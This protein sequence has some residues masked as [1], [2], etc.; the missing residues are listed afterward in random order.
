VSEVQASG[1]AADNH[2]RSAAWEYHQ[3][4]NHSPESVRAD[5]HRLDWANQPRPY[6]LYAGLPRLP[7]PVDPPPS[8]MPALV[9]I[10]GPAGDRSAPAPDLETL[11]SLLHYS[12]GIIRRLRFPGGVMDFRAAACT[13]ALYHIELYIV[14]RDLPGLDAGVYQFGAHDNALYRLRSGD[15]RAELEQAA[16]A[17][18][19]VARA[20]VVIVCT[21]T[22]WR[23][24]WK[25]QARAYRHAF[26]DS[27]TILANL[28][29]LA[30][31]HNLQA[32]I[33]TGFVDNAVS[34][35]LDLDAEREAALALIPIGRDA[36]PVEDVPEVPARLGL[37]TVPPSRAEVD[38]AAIRRIH[39]ASSLSSER[40][41]VAWRESQAEFGLPPP[42]RAVSQLRPLPPSALPAAPIEDVIRRRGSA[43]RFAPRAIGIDALSSMLEAA[44]AAIPADVL[45]SSGAPMSEL[46]LIVRAVEGLES[47]AY[48]Y[49][50]RQKALELLRAGD[51]TRQAEHL[52][53]GQ[54]LGAQAAV[55]VYFLADLEVI[56]S[57]LGNRGYR[58]AQLDAAVSAGRLYLAAYALGAGATGLTF[59]DDDVIAFFSPHASGKSVMFL[60]A[61]GVPARRSA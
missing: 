41:V 29:A 59:Y 5:R 18:P 43:R 40:E 48:V 39:A 2:D 36:D 55:N 60:L 20:P 57:A 52:D 49:Q 13:G 53:L 30:A 34:S 14:C 45:G 46:Y 21:T 11:T 28:L 61:L 23:N 9:A 3:A 58:A 10:S 44:T 19:A 56:L 8:T 15:H 50:R 24:A 25:Y 51:F 26:W 4:T 31:A 37:E 38:Y 6:K 16:A 54:E 17:E 47:G 32:R 7:L 22:F 35:L 12:S 27:G 1:A 42:A 33:V